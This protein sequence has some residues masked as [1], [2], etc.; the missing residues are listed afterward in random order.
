[1]GRFLSKASIRH[2]PTECKLFT[3]NRPLVYMSDNGTRYTIMTGDWWFDG[4]SFPTRILGCPISGCYLE[5]AILHDMNYKAQLLT[6]AKSDD[7]LKEGL[8]HSS[9][10]YSE[11]KMFIGVRIGGW[12]SWQSNTGDTEHHKQFI[13]VHKYEQ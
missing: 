1:M 6:R 9:S 4:A 11:W 3:L 12:V 7:L 10:E 8:N 5:D 2:H 13:K